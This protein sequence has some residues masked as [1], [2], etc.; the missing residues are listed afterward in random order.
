V[1][2]NYPALAFVFAL[3]VLAFIGLWHATFIGIAIAIVMYALTGWLGICIG[4]HRLFAHSSFRTVTW[5]EIVLAVLG[6]LALQGKIKDWTGMHRY[7]HKYADGPEDPTSPHRMENSFKGFLYSHVGWIM[8]R[9]DA[10]RYA[11]FVPRV[12]QGRSYYRWL[13]R[14]Y[15]PIQLA[16]AIAFYLLGGLPLFLWAFA[17]R[18]VFSWHCTF[19]VNS[20]THLWGD[21]PY[22][23]RDRSGNLWW[24]SILTGGE[25]WHNNHHAHPRAPNMGNTSWSFDPAW[26]IIRLLGHLGLATDIRVRKFLNE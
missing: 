24:V 4:Y 21:R 23:T 17:I 10:T 9:R 3:H 1:R 25:G 12:L 16:Q 2:I 20:A 15:W 8:L 26:W 5:V 7:H 19:L 11:N 22:P 14:W 18:V 13:D 6:I